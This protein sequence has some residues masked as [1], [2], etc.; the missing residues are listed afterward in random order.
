MQHDNPYG[1]PEAPI[2]PPAPPALPVRWW[3]IPVWALFVL[4]AVVVLQMIGAYVLV[5]WPFD[6]NHFRIELLRRLLFL[7]I[8]PSAAAFVLYLR[9]LKNT[10]RAP[11]MQVLGVYA[12]FQLMAVPVVILLNGS[13][14]GDE[15]IASITLN[16]IVC[17]LAYG[18]RR[19]YK[20]RGA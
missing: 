15:W 18:A 16:L 10:G 4:F 12:A 2:E 20:S 1:A 19:V 11:L 3:R 14:D 7:V 8:F 17:L 9:F 6:T 13:V 5:A